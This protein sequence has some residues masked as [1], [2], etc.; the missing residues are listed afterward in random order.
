MHHFHFAEPY[1]VL[2]CIAL[3]TKRSTG[4]IS[5]DAREL[6]ARGEIGL[7]GQDRTQQPLNAYYGKS[8]MTGLQNLTDLVNFQPWRIDD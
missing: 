3:H 4:F 8:P 6:Y 5:G 7:K 1:S 2:N